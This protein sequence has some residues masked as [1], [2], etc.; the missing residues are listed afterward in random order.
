MGGQI[1]TVVLPLVGTTIGAII[2]AIVGGIAGSS[3]GSL[4]TKAGAKALDVENDYAKVRWA[5][6]GVA[7]TDR[8]KDVVKEYLKAIGVDYNSAKI[9]FKG[10]KVE[11]DGGENDITYDQ[12]AEFEADLEIEKNKDK[13]FDIINATNELTWERANETEKVLSSYFENGDLSLLD[14]DLLEEA[15]ELNKQQLEDYVKQNQET[16]QIALN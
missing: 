6:M 7:G 14:P 10:D 16:L 15:T 1:G 4:A 3:V 5:G 2:G 12:L 11:I 13:L 9:N 8:G